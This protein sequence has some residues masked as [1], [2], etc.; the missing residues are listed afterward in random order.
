MAKRPEKR[1]RRFSIL[2]AGMLLT[3]WLPLPARAEAP[4]PS[5]APASSASSEAASESAVVIED[6]D[7]P[8]GAADALSLAPEKSSV[9]EVLL[10][11]LGVVG[12][13]AVLGLGL[14]RRQK[15]RE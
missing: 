1:I 6:E 10:A 15:K 3:M 2:L 7:T 11:T 9:P 5:A 13:A 14:A 12:G 4:Q 8:A